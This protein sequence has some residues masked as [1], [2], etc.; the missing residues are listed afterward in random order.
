MLAF[1]KRYQKHFCLI[2]NICS[3]LYLLNSADKI[4]I[5]ARKKNPEQIV[6]GGNGY[7]K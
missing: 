6:D 1:I 5:M 2:P 7:I 4:N 3:Y